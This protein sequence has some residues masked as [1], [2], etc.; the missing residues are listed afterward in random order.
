MVI[1]RAT[2]YSI[3]AVLHLAERHPAPVVSKQE[4]CDAAGVTPAFLTKILQPLIRGGIV[5]S[6]RGVAGGFLLARDPEKLTLLDVMRAAEEPMTL[7]LCLI[8]E[9]ACE[10]T[11]SCPIHDMWAEARERIEEVFSRRSLADL[12]REHRARVAAG[13]RQQPPST[14]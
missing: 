9:H 3:R 11:C 7:N 6:K 8:T 4:I 5:R 12:A 1:T 14:H 13:V 2:E 10:R